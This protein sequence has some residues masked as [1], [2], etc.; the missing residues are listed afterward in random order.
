LRV[1]ACAGRKRRPN[2]VFHL[3]VAFFFRGE[4]QTCETGPFGAFSARIYLP[5][6]SAHAT[7]RGIFPR[8]QDGDTAA[9]P[10]CRGQPARHPVPARTWRRKI[11]PPTCPPRPARAPRRMCLKKTSRTLPS[12]T[13]AC[14]RADEPPASLSGASFLSVYLV[15]F[16]PLMDV[17]G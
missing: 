6:Y 5:L 10:R 3:F 7:L 2:V 1:L 8:E 9:P 17:Q 16:S 14:E 11:S 15:C 4:Q 12:R 13:P